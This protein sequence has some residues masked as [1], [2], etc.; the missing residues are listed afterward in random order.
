ML[1]LTAEQKAKFGLELTTIRQTHSD[2]EAT[3]K[4]LIDTNTRDKMLIQRIKKHKDEIF[5]RIVEIEK[6]VLPDIIA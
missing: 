4:V 5:E 2:L 6:L 1:K 3:I